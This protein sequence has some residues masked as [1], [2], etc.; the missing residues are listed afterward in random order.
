MNLVNSFPFRCTFANLG[1]LCGEAGDRT[2]RD[3]TLNPE[4]QSVS[5]YSF[6][7]SETTP[8]SA[9]YNLSQLFLYFYNKPQELTAM[10]AE[11]AKFAQSD[12]VNSFP[13][14]VHLCE[15]WRSLP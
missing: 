5:M 13:F 10:V 7:P 15:P 4:E 11:R 14:T 9:F 2:A 12:L 8:L 6:A 1:D 3:A